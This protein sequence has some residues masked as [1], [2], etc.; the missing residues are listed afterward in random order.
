MSG[1]TVTA[2]IGL[3]SNL[4]G[5]AAQVRRAVDALAA[6]DGMQ[7][8]ACSSLYA[9]APMGPQDQ[10][11]YINAVAV[12]ETALTPSELLDALQAQEAAQARRRDRRWGP[13]TLDLDL[14]TYGDATISTERLQVPHPGLHL[15]AFVLYPLA[16]LDPA[17]RVPGLG[18]VQELL[19]ACSDDGIRRLGDHENEWNRA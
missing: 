19:A 7:V 16:E 13:R 11:D 6:H 14:L 17:R 10:P 2:C 5:P 3:G 4:D 9:S 8:T 12:V 18:P 1:A 15:R